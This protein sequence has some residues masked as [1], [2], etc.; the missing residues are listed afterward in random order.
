MQS[1]SITR[2]RRTSYAANGR[3]YSPSVCF[4]QEIPSHFRR[5]VATRFP[6]VI[7]VLPLAVLVLTLAV[8]FFGAFRPDRLTLYCAVY[9]AGY[10]ALLVY[11]FATTATETL[12]TLVKG[13][14]L[15]VVAPPL[16]LLI[17]QLYYGVRPHFVYPGSLRFNS[18]FGP[19]VETIAYGMTLAFVAAVLLGAGRVCRNVFAPVGKG[20]SSADMKQSTKQR[21][22][23]P[24]SNLSVIFWFFLLQSLLYSSMQLLGGHF[25]LLHG[26]YGLMDE[27][28]VLGINAWNAM[29]TI[30]L[31][32]ASGF[33]DRRDVTSKTIIWCVGAFVLGANLINGNRADV[34]GLAVLAIVMTAKVRLRL[35]KLSLVLVI[36]VLTVLLSS[37][38]ATYRASNGLGD[39]QAEV[40]TVVHM[41]D[42]WYIQSV[43]DFFGSLPLVISYASFDGGQLWHGRSYYIC[44]TCLLPGP[45]NPWRIDESATTYL[46][47]NYCMYNG[48]MYLPAELWINFGLLGVL[49]AAP[50]IGWAMTRIERWL[51]WD[52][53]SPRAAIVSALIVGFPRWILYGSSTFS[54]QVFLI[55]LFWGAATL[56]AS[57]LT[58]SN[59]SR[60]LVRRSTAGFS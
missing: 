3:R 57:W 27:S 22:G 41:S 30:C 21:T 53:S 26:S 25:A 50:L 36:A 39:R 59:T 56:L 35:S 48:G 40:H 52:T 44:L 47:K 42:S 58:A 32:L 55:V 34:I 7:R 60:S 10:V 15:V 19:R 24:A 43:N 33:Y 16:F 6:S 38:V 11:A 23:T 5:T 28:Q 20:V 29:G 13:L 9:L 49:I 51:A 37:A 1:R 31:V 18:F 14:V 8:T 45:L 46:Q 12:A 2:Q 54:K 17:G 4:D